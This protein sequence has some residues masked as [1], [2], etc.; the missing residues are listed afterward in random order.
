MSLK[1]LFNNNMQAKNHCRNAEPIQ[2]KF[3]SML[4]SFVFSHVRDGYYAELRKQRKT[5]N[6]FRNKPSFD[7][8]TDGSGDQSSRR[9]AIITKL[10]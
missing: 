8:S 5:I 9:L 4:T 3:R 6:T 7:V 1:L 2:S 10:T